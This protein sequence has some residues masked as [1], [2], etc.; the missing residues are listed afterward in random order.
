MCEG[1]GVH[2]G[3]LDVQHDPVDQRFGTRDE[4][5]P[6]AGNKQNGQ[7]KAMKRG[8]MTQRWSS[9]YDL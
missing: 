3:G 5:D 8:N 4:T 7:S 9:A 1:A 2:G 6:Q